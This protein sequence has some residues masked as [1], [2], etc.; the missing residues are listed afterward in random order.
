MHA[1]LTTMNKIIC[2]FSLIAPFSIPQFLPTYRACHAVCCLCAIG[3][4]SLS[5]FQAHTALIQALAITFG[6]WHSC[7]DL[8]ILRLQQ[9]SSA[10][11]HSYSKFMT[12]SSTRSHYGNNAAAFVDVGISLC[13]CGV[14][15]FF[16]R[17]TKSVDE[18]LQ[19][20]FVTV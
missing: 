8:H 7:S 2:Y 5:V 19:H 20:F 12:D 6:H 1:H 15:L 13:G 3:L 11:A 9:Q 17:A 16:R 14:Y 4:C 10:L 18:Y